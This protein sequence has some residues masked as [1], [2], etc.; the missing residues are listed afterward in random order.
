[1]VVRDRE[2]QATKWPSPPFLRITHNKRV[3]GLR[4]GPACWLQSA[5]LPGRRLLRHLAHALGLVALSCERLA[6]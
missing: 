6:A 4:P 1:V 5:K 2:V 3:P